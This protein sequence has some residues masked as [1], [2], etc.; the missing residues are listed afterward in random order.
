MWICWYTIN[1]NNIQICLSTYLPFRRGISGI[2]PA[3][4]WM[5]CLIRRC[6]GEDVGAHTS[7]HAFA[8]FLAKVVDIH[9]LARL[10]SGCIDT[11]M[12]SVIIQLT[13]RGTTYIWNQCEQSVSFFFSGHESSGVQM[14]D[15]PS[16]RARS[17]WHIFAWFH[18]L[19]C[20]SEAF[21]AQSLNGQ[22]PRNRKK[23]NQSWAYPEG[24]CSTRYGFVHFIVCVCVKICILIW[25]Q[26]PNS[27]GDSR[28]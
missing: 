8:W 20:C 12:M 9:R 19:W 22:R 3:I 15:C 11:E 23:R 27:T 28:V 7:L 17:K 5:C 18:V 6:L 21:D 16:L 2:L 1:L 26:M 10:Y 13:T 14:W 25:K 4:A 24:K